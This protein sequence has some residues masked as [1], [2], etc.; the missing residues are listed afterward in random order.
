MHRPVIGITLDYEPEGSFSNY[1]YYALRQHY[2]SAVTKAGGL[3]IGIPYAQEEIAAYL[4]RIDGLIVPGG[5][6]A[7]PPEWYIE[8]DETPY[9]CSPRLAF[10]LA[11]LDQALDRQMPLLG[12]CAGMQLLGGL[13]G[14]KMTGGIHRYTDSTINHFDATP[15]AEYA[16]TVTVLEETRLAE[17]VKTEHFK[18]NSHHQEAL[19]ELSKNVVKSAIAPDGIIE[20][21]EV[22]DHPF[23]LGLQWHPE[24]MQEEEDP[25][26]LI[27]KALIKE[28]QRA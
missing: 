12:I 3:P 2:F 15:I 25:S 23:A 27:F 20:A 4:D 10:D 13:L 19:V 22:R 28:A 11:L 8:N 24:C 14:C 7:S 16:H 9:E 5:T 17:I 18:I 1:P 21:I 6:F 26:F